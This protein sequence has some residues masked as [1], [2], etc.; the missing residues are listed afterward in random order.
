MRIFVLED[1]EE[2]IKQFKKAF[3]DH[4]WTMVQTADAAI[5]HLTMDSEYDIV[6]LDHDLGGQQYV[7]TRDKNTGS[8]V[9]RWMLSD[10][11][12]IPKDKR[13]VIHSM[14]PDAATSMHINLASAGF[15]AIDHIPF[16]TLRIILGEI[17]AGNQ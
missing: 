8:E 7:S 4:T 12:T 14:N 13:I 6:F 1:N 9:V 15:T 17:A 11:G 2:R 16:I 5:R 3:A 10:E